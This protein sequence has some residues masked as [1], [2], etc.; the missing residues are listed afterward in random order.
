MILILIISTLALSVYG[1][2]LNNQESNFKDSSS[3]IGASDSSIENT[4]SQEPSEKTG[5]VVA[6]DAGHGAMDSG[7]VGV[8]GVL[9]KDINLKIV[10]KLKERLEQSG[11]TVV[12]TRADDTALY[13]ETD[14]NKKMA[15]MRARCKTIE[16]SNAD[17]TVS[18][19]QNSYHESYVAG[20][21]VFYY[22]HSE[23]GKTLAEKIQSH[24]TDV[25][26]EKNKRQPKANSDYYLLLHVKC[27]IVI[28]ECGFLSNWEEAANL[29]DDNY[30]ESMAQAIAAAIVEYLNSN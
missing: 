16:D 3:T 13:S 21:Q 9:E 12:L 23:N 6:L 8:N 19:H 30:Q 17:I 29:C 4:E 5:F 20:A 25:L 22:T 10:L 26:G 11:V 28:V 15:D 14:S 18:I 27:P 7:K 1:A 24:F 2:R